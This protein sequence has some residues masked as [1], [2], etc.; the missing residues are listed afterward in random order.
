MPRRWNLLAALAAITALLVF[1]GV[2]GF[3]WRFASRVLGPLQEG[4]APRAHAASDAEL[5][6]LREEVIRL[7]AEN[8]TLRTRLSEYLSIRGEGG[9]PPA[10]VVVVRGR[11]ISRTQRANC[12]LWVRLDVGAIDGVA[13]G[14]PVRAAAG[15]CSGWW[16][17][18]RRAAAWCRRW[19]TP[20]AASPPR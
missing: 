16:S 13:K 15:A 12:Q 9:V 14:L 11:I 10:Q 2:G 6:A 1:T 7:N 3:A 5:A 8:V 20:R 17:G 19:P 4:L 18:S